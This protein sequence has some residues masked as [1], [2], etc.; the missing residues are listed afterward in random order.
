MEV[1]NCVYAIIWFTDIHSPLKEMQLPKSAIS[2]GQEGTVPCLL[3]KMTS[4]IDP[5]AK[6]TCVYSSREGNL[7]IPI[8]HRLD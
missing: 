8:C 4:F 7:T 5:P 2:L 1:R 3:G 6:Q